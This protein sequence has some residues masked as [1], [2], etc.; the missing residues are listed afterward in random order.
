MKEALEN[1]IAQWRNKAE[2][3]RLQSGPS[4]FSECAD[5]QELLLEEEDDQR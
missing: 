3:E 5:Q 1:L 4:A 2:N